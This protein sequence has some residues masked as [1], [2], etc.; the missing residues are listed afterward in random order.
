MSNPWVYF[1]VITLNVQLESDSGNYRMC[2]IAK[3]LVLP[4]DPRW[5]QLC[6]L[7]CKVMINLLSDN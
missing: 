3:T 6:K 1:S 4:P 7:S 2:L 5:A